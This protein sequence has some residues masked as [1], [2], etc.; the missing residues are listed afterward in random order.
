[1]ALP[2][3][4]LSIN[5]CLAQNTPSP[6]ERS[7]RKAPK[8]FKQLKN[9]K[10]ESNYYL[11]I[12]FEKRPNREAFGKL[13]QHR[14]DLLEFRSGNT[15]LASIPANLDPAILKSLNIKSVAEPVTTQ[16]MDK[17]LISKDYPEWTQAVSGYIDLAIIFH[18]KTPATLIH[19]FLVQNNIEV[20]EDKHRGNTTIVARVP[21]S[22]IETIAASPLVSYVDVKQ[23]PVQIL[24]H[25]TRISQRVNVLNNPL[26]NGYDL[27]GEGVIVG[28]G[29]GGELGN[30]I[31]F[32][33]R[34]INKANGTFNSFGDHGDHVSGIIGGAG[35]LDPRHRG[36][37]PECTIITQKTSQITYNLDEYYN[38]YGMVLTNNSYGTSFNCNTNGSYNYSAQNLDWQLREFPKVLHVF[39]A[40]NSGSGTCSPYPQGYHS[41]LRY[42]QS[43]K[44]V[45]TVGMAEENRTIAGSSSRGPVKDGRLK[46]EIIGIGRNV[47]STSRDYNYSTKGGTSM[48]APAV[49]GTLA[50]LVEEYRNDNNGEDPDGALL[51]AIACNTADDLGNSGPDYIYGF[52]LINGI[53]AVEVIKQGQFQSG[54]I[55]EGEM[56]AHAVNV[57]D[58]VKQIKI[59]LY[60]PDKE[61]AIYPNKALVNDLDISV[62]APDGSTFLPWVLDHHAEGVANEA[63][64][65][66][67]TLNNIEQITIDVPEAGIYTV[68]VDGKAVPI[69][70]QKFYTTYDL[71]REEIIVTHP[72]GGESFLPSTQELLSWDADNTNTS[73][74]KLEYSLDGGNA[75]LLIAPEINATQRTY[76]WTVPQNFSPNALVR[77]SKNQG[78]ISAQ[79]GAFFT[80]MD[81]PQNLIATPICEKDILLNWEGSEYITTYEISM[82]NGNEMITLGTTED[83]EFLVDENMELEESYWFSVC[84]VDA[85]N[86]RSQRVISVMSVPEDIEICPWDNHPIIQQL[87]IAVTGRDQTSS[88][89]L[90]DEPVSIFVKN[91]GSNNLEQFDMYYSINGGTPVHEIYQGVIGSGETKRVEFQTKADL[92]EV[93]TYHIDAWVAVEGNDGNQ[94]YSD[95]LRD[96]QLGE[97]L[98]NAPVN[99]PFKEYFLNAESELYTANKLGLKGCPKWDLQTQAMGVME[100]R[101]ADAIILRPTVPANGMPINNHAVLTLNMSQY[102]D[103]SEL[104]ELDFDY[105]I[106]LDQIPSNQQVLENTVSVRGSDT[107]EWIK[108][109]TLGKQNLN[110]SKV[111]DLNITD[112]LLEHD[113]DFTTSFQI[114]FSNDNNIPFAFTNV[115]V[116]EYEEP[117]LTPEGDFLPDFTAVQVGEEVV[118]T[119]TPIEAHG[120]HFEIEVI[121]NYNSNV[122]FDVIGTVVAERTTTQP[123]YYTF[124]DIAPGKKGRRYYRI[125]QVNEDGSITFSP[126][127]SVLI[128]GEELDSVFPNPFDKHLKLAH[129][130]EEASTIQILLLGQN[131]SLLYA[132]EVD[133]VAGTQM[134]PINIEKHCP[135]GM[136][137]L[138]VVDGTKATYHKV[139]KQ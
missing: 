15:Y 40:G 5:V 123:Y 44:N 54:E 106:A 82:F 67:D 9:A 7:I 101:Q 96:G 127:L 94:L 78:D 41:V 111:K 72:S 56:N 39:A 22:K 4:S 84:A 113:Q 109:H 8:K 89:L 128:N 37:A 12:D 24:N 64:R 93:G 136:Y 97:Q 46:P 90:D 53:R 105:R 76:Q 65:S 104:I 124:T 137:I 99:L 48:A 80:I 32:G 134:I 10:F 2:L 49:T 79:S 21:E 61:A 34:V 132:N 55:A 28:V 108:I 116:H 20:L 30:H 115:S 62:I 26:A 51:K 69:G 17:R 133:V 70:P 100:V 120:I 129:T 117:S 1:M 139:I 29:D 81:K 138:K 86:N 135:S 6:I 130:A 36:M 33:N 63:V 23:E 68:V 83:T 13:K 119:W 114:R 95:S 11:L 92:T 125:K 107:D 58:G 25:E 88:S 66:I 42:Y 45:L 126:V 38:D 75:W 18:E 50:L 73:T 52:G 112:L 35:N 3:I 77:V 27:R 19:N 14:I 71:I 122:D 103:M 118:L 74:F 16:K 121:E 47:T 59:M 110:W 43:A 57:P 102:S 131:G 31:D 98:D 91:I 85:G 87:G 60:W